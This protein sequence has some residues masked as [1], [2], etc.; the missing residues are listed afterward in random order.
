MQPIDITKQR[1]WVI[2]IGSSVI[3]NDG[4]G[5]NQTL[6][7]HWA[8][9]LATM[10][11]AGC[12]LVLVSSGAIAAG[13][14]QLNWRQ[15]PKDIHQ[16]RAAAAIGQ[17][18]LIQAYE[19]TFQQHQIN[20]AQCLLTNDDLRDRQRYLNAR[21]T[22]QALLKLKII[23][24]I[25]ENDTIATDEIKLGDNDTLAALVAN[26]IGADM[27]VIL[28]DQAGLFDKDPRTHR[29]AKLIPLAQAGDPA[30]LNM[31]GNSKGRLG[32]GGM[33]TKLQA[34]KFAARS[35]TNTL[36]AAG[37]TPNIFDALRAG[38]QMGTLL[39]ANRPPL[40]ARKQWLANQLTAK[41]TLTL[42][43]GACRVLQQHSSSLLS[44]GVTA[45]A[46]HFQRG[47]LVICQDDANTPIA[48]GLTNYASDDIKK[49]QGKN[50]EEISNILGY[51]HEP[52][53]IDRSNLVVL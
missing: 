20:T 27:L 30:L 12:E 5:L 14:S 43:R 31:A 46:G 1:C 18:R 16:V 32:S 47:D 33:H 25:N 11:R 23:P 4:S 38:E 6:L 52:E 51:F 45:V 28:T 19:S 40:V 49:I 9:Q 53:L 8:A 24:I 15:R 13:I 26:L 21:Y 50:S 22:L 2:K 36:I 37:H 7:S 42:D 35:G 17:M 44:I 10:Q 29:D 48:R 3:T 39:V 34:A 41:G